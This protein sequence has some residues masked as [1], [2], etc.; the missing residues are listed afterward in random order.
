M[1]RAGNRVHGHRLRGLIV[2]LWR[3]GLRIHEALALAEADLDPRR[4]SLL[5]PRGKGGRRREAGMDD[6]AWEQL[7]P[8][9]QAR[10]KPPVGPLFCIVNGPTRGRPWSAGAARSELRTVA[11]EA[12]VRRRFA[13]HQLRHAHAVEM[14]REGVPL[15]VIQRQLGTP[16]SSRPSRCASSRSGSSIRRWGRLGGCGKLR[17]PGSRIERGRRAR[18][19]SGHR[20]AAIAGWRRRRWGRMI[21]FRGASRRLPLGARFGLTCAVEFRIL[22]SLEVVRDEQ[23]LAVPGGRPRALLAML[24]LGA[25]RTVARE[26]LIDGLWGD[27]VPD[28]GAKMVQICVSLL[29][30]VLPPDMLCTRPPGYLLELDPESLDLNRFVRLAGEGRAALAAGDPGAASARLREALTLWRGPALR[31]FSEPFAAPEAERLEELHLAALESRIEADL[32]RGGAAELVG[33]L[34]SLTAEYPLRERLRGVLM[35]ALYRSGR[36]AEALAAYHDMR[37]TLDEELGLL[38]SPALQQLQQ[39]ILRHDESLQPDSDEGRPAG[40]V[41]GGDQAA[42][43]VGRDGELATLSAALPT[44][45]T[46]AGAA[47][48]VAGAPGIGKTRLAHELSV[49]AAEA[50]VEVAWG[51]C[52]EREVPP[53]YWPWREAIR[54]L[55]RE[56]TAEALAE[57]AGPDAAA[58]ARLVPDLRERLGSVTAG[59]PDDDPQLARFRLFDS[60]TSFL[61]RAAAR[62]PLLVVLDDLHAADADSLALLAFLARRLRDGRLVVVATLRADESPLDHPLAEA[63][64]AFRRSGSSTRIALTGLP[65][66]ALGELVRV[67]VGSAP[68]SALVAELHAGTGGNPLYVEE[69]TRL[70]LDRGAGELSGEAL[71]DCFRQA[72]PGGLRSAIATR[73][74]ALSPG[75]RDV[76]IA[77][78]VLGR[79]L[80]VARL[81]SLTGLASDDAVLDAIEEAVQ[82]GLL[83]EHPTQPGRHEF[84]HQLVRDAVMGQLPATRRARLH[85]HA[86]DA[87]EHLYGA[88]ADAR[89]TEIAHHL[90]AAGA[91]AAPS[92]IVHFCSRG[93]VRALGGQAYEEAQRLFRQALAAKAGEPMDDQTADL[94]VGLARA[95]LA[96]LRLHDKPAF[97]EAAVRMRRAFDH[98]AGAR[99]IARAVEIAA[100]PV[101]P[102]YRTTAVD[103]YRDLTARALALVVPDSLQAG[104]LLASSGWFAGANESDLE[105]AMSAFEQAVAI[106]RRHGDDALET[107]TLLNAAHVDFQHVRWIE[108]ATNATAALALAQ[109]AGDARAEIFARVWAARSAMVL[110]D[111]AGA[112]AHV[113]ASVALAERLQEPFWL[114]GAYLDAT[115]LA[116][117]EGRWDAARSAAERALAAERGDTRALGCRALIEYQCG[118]RRRGD[119][120]LGRL[121][122]IHAAITDEP[123]AV[124][125]NVMA[126]FIPLLSRIAGHG[127]EHFRVA[128][129][130]AASA[131]AAAVVHPLSRL[132][133]HAGLGLM[134][135]AGADAAA[136]TEHAEALA[137]QAGTVLLV[138]TMST[139]RLLGLLAA[140]SGD[141]DGAARHFDR[142]LAFCREAGYRPEWAWTA[143]DYVA[144]VAPEDPGPLLDEA[145][146]VASELGMAALLEQLE[147]PGGV[148]S[149]QEPQM[150]PSKRRRM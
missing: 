108:C 104:R 50:G 135:T 53:P 130:A 80:T 124:A 8:W 18:R 24:L 70:A 55:A 95:E 45:S 16:T 5:V 60:V 139:D 131:L 66:A 17:F 12:G 79:E 116:V 72:L 63:L 101:P 71:V 74:S 46:A 150:R 40:A 149:E 67:R 4:G 78:A 100:L 81:L 115:W 109:R 10:V 129:E 44:A 138:A 42:G 96:T 29:R 113:T 33:E 89:A 118:E 39:A 102:I 15:I 114:N 30:R 88:A 62:R 51:R 123:H 86:A 97:R 85:L 125:N 99:D 14:A 26:R 126:A 52:Y 112:H 75:C 48:L 144:L 6:W 147:R 3:A 103:E 143:H 49:R 19:R 21:E 119:E 94:F 27:D 22:G 82:A 20:C 111:S 25:G 37:R 28:S 128:R 142:A 1:R 121:I 11:R 83:T 107:R 122:D 105:R 41:G 120:R 133:V 7:E 61:M 31:E 137:T 69:V 134:A 146:A 64:G 136:A 117:L 141:A 59:E 68:P 34:E 9:L 145:R 32:A 148:S 110:G 47:V 13:P 65:P 84:V 98:Y 57:A 90:D 73:M 38:P 91:L 77:A 76:L 56:W 43:F 140:T 87:L 23:P 132:M 54:S 127:D 2:V 35:L 92:R 93:A 106:A 58:I 36:Q